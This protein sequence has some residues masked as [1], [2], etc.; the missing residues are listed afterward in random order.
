MLQLSNLVKTVNRD[1]SFLEVIDF[2]PFFIRVKSEQYT[3][4]SMHIPYLLERRKSLARVHGIHI[5]VFVSLCPWA[6]VAR[7]GIQSPQIC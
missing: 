2:G 3:M 7:A 5:L 6:L 4:C 1:R